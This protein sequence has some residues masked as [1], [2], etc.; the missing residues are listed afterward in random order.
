MKPGQAFAG[1]SEFSKKYLDTVR[2]P[3]CNAAAKEVL[4]LGPN[5]KVEQE[6]N[7]RNRPIVRVA[8]KD[9]SASSLL[10]ILVQAFVGWLNHESNLVEHRQGQVYIEPAAR[11]KVGNVFS[12]LVKTYVWCVEVSLVFVFFQNLSDPLA[13][14]L[15]QKDIGV[16]HQALARV[17]SSSL[18]AKL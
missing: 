16:Q 1:C 8:R 12:R 5:R 14:D 6:R 18:S 7:R 11:G 13:E 2:C 10:V 17:I 4:I 9:T 15:S 3:D